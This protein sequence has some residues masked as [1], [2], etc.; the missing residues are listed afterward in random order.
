M[1]RRRRFGVS[2]PSSIAEELDALAAKLRTDRSR[3]VEHAVAS[4]LNEYRHYLHDHECS[5][6][7]II[8]GSFD[9]GEVASLLDRYKDIVVSTT[10][11]HVNEVCTEIVVVQGPS[12]RIAE[13]HTRLS[14]VKGCNVRYIPFSTVHSSMEA[15]AKPG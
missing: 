9:R 15:G 5:G 11:V 1:T 10:H 14:S 7:M 6:V 8:L 12:G 3:L 2:L 4:F 13:M